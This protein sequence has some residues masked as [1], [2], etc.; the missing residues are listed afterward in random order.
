MLPAGSA[1]TPARSAEALRR[2]GL[3]SE[4]HMTV[5]DSRRAAAG[6]K[7]DARA[8]CSFSAHNGEMTMGFLTWVVLGLIVGIL[9]DGS[10]RAGWRRFSMTVILGWSVPWWGLCQHLLGIG[11]VAGLTCRASSSPPLAP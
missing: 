3:M 7:Q 8:I 11:T 10:C 6:Y 2:R 5:S 1:S 9:A 4:S